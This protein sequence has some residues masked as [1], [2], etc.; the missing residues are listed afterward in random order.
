MQLGTIIVLESNLLPF[1]CFLT[2]IDN[3]FYLLV[4]VQIVFGYNAT[5][6]W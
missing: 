2:F 1:L 4:L 6:M 5:G 3:L